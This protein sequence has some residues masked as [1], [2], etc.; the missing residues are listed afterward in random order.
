MDRTLAS[1]EVEMTVAWAPAADT[2][3]EPKLLGRRSLARVPVEVA[4]RL[5]V[6]GLAGPLPARTR[7][8][9]VGGLC[10]A[11]PSCFPLKDLRRVA[12]LHANETVEVDA[13]G[14]WQAAFPGRDA[15]LSGVRFPNVGGRVRDYLW[16]VVHDQTKTLS[17]W[18]SQESEMRSL[19]LPDLVE[20]IHAMRMRQSMNGEVVF[21]QGSRQAGDDSIFVVMTGS[22]TLETLTAKGRSVELGSVTR[23]QLLGGSA[24]LGSKARLE[25]ATVTRPAV[26]LE[27]SRASLA[28]LQLVY[29]MLAAELTTIV[30]RTYMERQQSALNRA[31]DR[32]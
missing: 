15:F 32:A 26:F 22:V 13:E 14:R 5:H 11:T 23:G 10:V 6:A 28:F 31:V 1:E 12:V 27:I 4:L 19:A 3:L 2:H 29:P 21:R 8:V 7:D 20:L 18:L 9:G 25:T 24:L 16:D 30:M 17:T